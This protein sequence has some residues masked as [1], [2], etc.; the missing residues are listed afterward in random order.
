MRFLLLTLLLPALAWASGF[1]T[2]FDKALAEAKKAKKPVLV[3]FFGIWCPPCNE[4][5]ELVF[6]HPEFRKKAARWVTVKVDADQ[7]ESWKAKHRYKVGGYP[8]VLLLKPDGEEVERIVGFR[9][10]RDFLAVM[11]RAAKPGALTLEKAC[12]RKEPEHLLRCVKGRAERKESV[13]AQAAFAE[14][15]K[16]LKPGSYEFVEAASAAADLET[17]RDQK[18]QRLLQLMK[19]HPEFPSALAWASSY[20]DTFED[21]SKEKPDAEVLRA[22]ADKL[23]AQ[24]SSP[25]LA[26]TGLTASDLYELRAMVVSTFHPE[27]TKQLWA[28]AVKSLDDAAKA[29]GRAEP[30]RGFVLERIGCLERAGREDEALELAETYRA[31]YP[32]EFTFHF[33]VA[34]LLWHR[35]D[36]PKALAA[37]EKAYAKSYGDNKLRVALLLMDL[38]P[39]NARVSDASR[40]YD[41]V[42]KEIRPDAKLEVRTHRYLKQLSEAKAKLAVGGKKP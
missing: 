8:T 36:A 29:S 39:A 26:E 21:A 27:L 35:K 10:L 23:P 18:R 3:D 34:N 28:D 12:T 5:D 7:P 31:K 4:L 33:R 42:T 16:K 24:L 17:N 25:R 13:E 6:S 19:D 20:L 32:D 1:R 30:G 22:V 2:D 15:S 9:P 38:Y 14:L 37:A 40:V 41:E 11:E